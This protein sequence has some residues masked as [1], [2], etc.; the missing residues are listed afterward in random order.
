MES[1]GRFEDLKGM[2]AAGARRF[3]QPDL[4]SIPP[5]F[6]NIFLRGKTLRLAG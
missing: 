4:Y 5:Q 2:K 1:R 3:L 6:G